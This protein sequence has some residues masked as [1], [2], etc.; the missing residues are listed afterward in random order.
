MFAAAA[1]LGYITCVLA[2]FAAI[3]VIAR[4]TATA[5]RMLALSISVIVRH[6]IT[7]LPE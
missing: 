1:D 5:T 7:F 2:V 6:L 3:L 4:H